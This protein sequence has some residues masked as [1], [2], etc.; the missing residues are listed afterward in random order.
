MVHPK[1]RSAARIQQLDEAR[2]QAHN[3]HTLSSLKKAVHDAE[4]ELSKSQQQ[5]IDLES[6]L[7]SK[8]HQCSELSTSLLKS[9]QT[10]QE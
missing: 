9:E 10:S 7:E 8:A 6:A 4:S 3:A 1:A 2:D 5:I